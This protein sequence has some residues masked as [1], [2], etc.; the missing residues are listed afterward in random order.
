MPNATAGVCEPQMSSLGSANINLWPSA[1]HAKDYLERA[2]AIPHRREGE[3]TL[4][5]FLPQQINRFLDIGAG[6]G[7]LLSLVKSRYPASEWV[8]LDFSPTML[9]ILR[10]TFGN[11][12]GLTIVEHDLDQALPAL[13]AFDAVISSLPFI[14]WRTSVSSRS[15]RRFTV[16]SNPA[17]S[18]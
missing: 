15:S 8:A 11:Q 18:S 16:C 17:Q 6:A 3:A 13:G 7:R 9:K 1:Q 2:D 10:D 12:P 14:M 5:E 4:L